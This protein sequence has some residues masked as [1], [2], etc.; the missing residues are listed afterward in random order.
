MI[1]VAEQARGRTP[2]LRRRVVRSA[3]RQHPENR[4]WS[5]TGAPNFRPP[6]PAAPVFPNLALCLG[7]VL[8]AEPAGEF[9]EPLLVKS[10]PTLRLDHDA[11]R[12]RLCGEPMQVHL[13][14][15][16]AE[17]IVDAVEQH[18]EETL[19]L[20]GRRPP[21][22]P[23]VLSAPTTRGRYGNLTPRRSSPR[24]GRQLGVLRESGSRPC[25]KA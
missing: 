7:H 10:R 16:P 19:D 8:A 6:L 5:A 18:A 24:R 20:L 17:I 22:Q 2:R 1:V 25:P 21:V 23:G 3:S 15:R 13:M 11:H 14:R 9:F 12:L 4:L